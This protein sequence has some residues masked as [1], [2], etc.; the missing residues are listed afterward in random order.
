[1]KWRVEP[2]LRFR[3]HEVIASQ[4]LAFQRQIRWEG[5]RG[6]LMAIEWERWQS[7]LSHRS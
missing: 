6:E 4:R 5:N 3:V 1:M 7:G 2:R